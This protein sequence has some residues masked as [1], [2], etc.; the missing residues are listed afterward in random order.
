METPILRLHVNLHVVLAVPGP[1][2]LPLLAAVSAPPAGPSSGH[3]PGDVCGSFPK[4]CTTLQILSYYTEPQPQR[5][6]RPPIHLD[7]RGYKSPSL[8]TGLSGIRTVAPKMGSQRLIHRSSYSFLFKGCHSREIMGTGKME[9][10]CP[11]FI[12]TAR[13]GNLNLPLTLFFTHTIMF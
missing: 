5:W 13:A 8:T 7:Y 6:V 4:N 2:R 3:I 10:W 9:T 12:S 1:H 11:R